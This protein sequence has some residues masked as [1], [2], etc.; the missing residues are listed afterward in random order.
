[1]TIMVAHGA[2][3]GALSPF[4]PTGIIADDLMG[5]MGMSGHEWSIYLANLLANAAVAFGGYSPSAAGGCL[6]DAAEQADAF[7]L[8]HDSPR[9]RRRCLPLRWRHVLTLAVIAALIVG[10]VGFSAQVGM[11][12]FAAAA[13]LS[14]LRVADEKAPFARCPG[15]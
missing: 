2:V 8:E 10:V 4:A 6:N 7:A 15:A 12:A 9:T 11:G 3:A 1:M 13:L 14:L 5:R